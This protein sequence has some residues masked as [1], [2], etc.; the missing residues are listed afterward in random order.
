ME[1][2]SSDLSELGRLNQDPASQS[3]HLSIKTIHSHLDWTIDWDQRTINGSVYHAFQQRQ[4]DHLSSEVKDNVFHGIVLDTSYLK[5]FRVSKLLYDDRDRLQLEFEVCEKHPVL[6]SAL[7][8]N[9]N[10]EEHNVSN[11]KGDRVLIVRIDY[12]TTSDCTALGWLNPSQ[13]ASG[14]HPFL[15]SQCQAIH[16]RSL[17]PTQDTPSI[18]FTYTATVKSYLPVL[19]SAR[20]ISNQNAN[21]RQDEFVDREINLKEKRE[22]IY[23]FEQ[24][25]KITSYLIAIASGELVYKRMSKRTGVWSDPLNID[26]SF[27]E[28][29]SSTEKFIEIAESLVGIEYD[30]GTYDVLVLPP[31][32]PYGGM[33][34][35]NLTFL[36]P[37]LLTGDKSLVDVVAHEI[38]H[39][40]FGNNVGCANWG[41]FWLNEGW[42]TYLERLIL[43]KL[44]GKA[45]RY[46]SYIIGRK[47]LADDLKSFEDQPRFQQLEIEYEFGEDPDQAFSNV[48]YDK[49]SNFLLYLEEVVGGLDIF[50]KY[51]NNY[52]KTF[53]GKSLD[54]KIWKDHL[55]QFFGNQI[56]VIERLNKVDWEAWLHGRGLEL[57]VQPKYDT[58]LADAAYELAE[59]WKMSNDDDDDVNDLNKKFDKRDTKN[60]TSNQIV[61]FLETLE[62][63]TNL[64]LMLLEFMDSIYRFDNSNNQE[65]RLRW[66][67]NS[68]KV[69]NQ[70]Y[71]GRAADW[72]KDKGRMKF[73]R[74]I[75]KALFKVDPELAV[76]TFKQNYDFYHPICRNL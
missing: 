23:L 42:T 14:N 24:P 7:K 2:L 51:L 48:P 69:K 3:N 36:T 19:L 56:E 63:K 30:W 59:R 16:A 39:S 52:V 28:F 65:I 5:I 62:S 10:D 76:N 53:K 66:Y 17:L 15:Y 33:E 72:I 43:Y 46:F 58:S 1:P 55:F 73:V 21:D 22:T 35:S 74:P 31:S 20:R 70:K 12:S 4:Q 38:S 47:A 71:C 45:E 57:P 6:G 13:T 64:K 11:C 27:E 68:I 18:K 67:L 25:I 54:T 75:Y 9:L 49:G 32:F 29:Q 60:F 26:S 37:S 40:W 8:I 41:S 44:H 34:N 61:V 50:L